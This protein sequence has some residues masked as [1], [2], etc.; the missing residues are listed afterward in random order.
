LP[1][2]GRALSFACQRSLRA[3]PTTWQIRPGLKRR[4]QE[5]VTDARRLVRDAGRIVTRGSELPAATMLTL[6]HRLPLLWT[7]SPGAWQQAEL[8][9][10]SLEKPLV[11][12]RVWAALALSPL[13]FWLAVARAW[14]PRDGAALPL[15]LAALATAALGDTI[16]PVHRRV[17][18]NARRLSRRSAR[19]NAALLR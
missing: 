9:R 5:D 16:G 15:E 7:A 1:A 4:K 12:G 14:G 2:A 17:T 8:W 18:R 10:M 3:L 13:Q 6:A 19:R 11:L